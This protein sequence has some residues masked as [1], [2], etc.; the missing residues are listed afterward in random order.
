MFPNRTPNASWAKLSKHVGEAKLHPAL[1][2]MVLDTFQN[3]CNP[4]D[5]TWLWVGGRHVS[6]HFRCEVER[7][8][9]TVFLPEMVLRCNMGKL[10]DCGLTYQFSLL[11]EL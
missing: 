8:F 7:I 1:E 10:L 6:K 2:S 4:Q 9:R 11:G 5:L 3:T